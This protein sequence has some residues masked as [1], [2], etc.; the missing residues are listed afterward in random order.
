MLDRRRAPGIDYSH[1][2]INSFGKSLIGLM[3][4]PQRLHAYRQN[5]RHFE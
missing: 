5:Y 3:Q 1:S 2:I 4:E